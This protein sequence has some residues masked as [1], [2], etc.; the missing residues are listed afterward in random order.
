MG[1]LI[2]NRWT[3][4]MTGEDRKVLKVRILQIMDKE[5][6][7]RLGLD[8][9]YDKR[10]KTSGQHGDM[11]QDAPEMYDQTPSSDAFPANVWPNPQRKLRDNVNGDFD[12][13]EDEGDRDPRIPF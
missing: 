3:D 8:D 10:T 4:K 1:T 2:Y 13:F 9:T 7:E 12:G 6:I 5:D 11:Y